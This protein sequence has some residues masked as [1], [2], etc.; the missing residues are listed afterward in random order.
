MIQVRKN[1]VSLDAPPFIIV[2]RVVL[3]A[4]FY[5]VLI[6]TLVTTTSL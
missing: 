6:T 5:V 4:R 3:D 2:C 1:I